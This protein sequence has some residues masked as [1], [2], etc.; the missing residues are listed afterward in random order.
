M[1]QLPVNNLSS[2]RK[3]RK[4]VKKVLGDIGVEFCREHI[5]DYKDFVPNEFYIKNTTWDDVC[6]WDPSMTKSQ[7]SSNL[8][9]TK[10]KEKHFLIIFCLFFKPISI[11]LSPYFLCLFRSTAQSHSVV[12][13]VH[14][15]PSFSLPTRV[16]F[17]MCTVRT[18]KTAFSLTAP[19]ALTMGTKRLWR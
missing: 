14:S 13:D 4:N 8:S 10:G 12:Q 17:V 5:D 19:I 6:M 16:T 15:P 11:F 2:L 3:A 7:V 1:F 18:L 9:L